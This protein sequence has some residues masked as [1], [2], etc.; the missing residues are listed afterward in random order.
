MWLYKKT[1]QISLTLC[2]TYTRHNTSNKIQ[3][4]IITNKTV[5]THKMPP[6]A[7]PPRSGPVSNNSPITHKTLLVHSITF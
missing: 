7:V 3:T 1:A 4:T 2:K 5:T 6:I